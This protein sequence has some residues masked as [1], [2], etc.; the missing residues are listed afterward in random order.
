[1]SYSPPPATSSRSSA[2]VWHPEPGAATIS[3]RLPEHPAVTAAAPHQLPGGA[4]AVVPAGTP[5]S[6]LPVRQGQ[7]SAP[8][9]SLR[10]PSPRP[11]RSLASGLTGSA[12]L[13]GLVGTP[14]RAGAQEREHNPGHQHRLPG[15]GRDQVTGPSRRA[16]PRTGGSR[17]A[18]ERPP[19]TGRLLPQSGRPLS[20]PADTLRG[21]GGFHGWAPALLHARWTAGQR[22]APTDLSSAGASSWTATDATPRDQ[23]SASMSTSSLTRAVATAITTTT[24]S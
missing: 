12:I 11:T 9:L 3:G 2:R 7:T 1:M 18:G 20:Y 17:R 24:S 10:P 21:A 16:A 23:S 14:V 4:H 22:E 6:P 8:R 13:G 19:E 5:A 15:Q